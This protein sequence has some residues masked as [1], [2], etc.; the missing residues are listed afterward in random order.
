[1]ADVE[2]PYYI[3]LSR[4][5]RE[6]FPNTVVSPFLVI[7]GTDARH[8]AP[9]TD[10]A[11][12]FTPAYL[13][14]AGLQSIHAVNERISF[15][16]CAI[17]VSFYIAYIEEMANLPEEIDAMSESADEV[18]ETTE[19]NL[20]DITAWEDDEDILIPSL[21]ESIALTADVDESDPDEAEEEPNPEE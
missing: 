7:G 8:Y 21:E 15:E 11:F 5:V 1:V 9:V 13:D 6:A 3:R 18:K 10:N 4:L 20:E 12:R 14:K 16:N 19:E 2:S 17:M